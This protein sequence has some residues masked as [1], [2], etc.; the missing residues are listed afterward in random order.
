MESSG[1]W[2]HLVMHVTKFSKQ[3]WNSKSY[4]IETF[5]TLT[6][7]ALS[8]ASEKLKSHRIINDLGLLS[9]NIY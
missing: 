8:P 9:H 1:N 2:F 4:Q 3:K 7:I 6:L 5:S